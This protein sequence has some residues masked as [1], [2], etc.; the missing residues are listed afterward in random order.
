MA[1]HI[2]EELWERLGHKECII[3]S[4]W[5]RYSEEAIKEE[6]KV[7]VIEI[8]GKVRARISVDA[9]ADDEE[10]KDKALSSERIKSLIQDKPI[11]KVFVVQKKLV[12][13]VV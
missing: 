1:P 13:I 2:C 5:P 10:I 8:N 7:V 9:N 6:I 3:R 4:P 11:K 12:N